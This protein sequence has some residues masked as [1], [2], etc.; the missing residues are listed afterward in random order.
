MLNL[1]SQETNGSFQRYF[2]KLKLYKHAL[3]NLDVPSGQRG[4]GEFVAFVRK[5]FE[6][7]NNGQE[8]LITPG[9]IQQLEGIGFDWVRRPTRKKRK[10]GSAT[11][12]S[13]EDHIIVL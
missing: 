6:C 2:E 10:L 4:L 9:E 13:H 11:G 5:Q 7:L 8:S 1:L 12:R 3:N